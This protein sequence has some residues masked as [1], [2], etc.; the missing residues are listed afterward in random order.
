MDAKSQSGTN[1]GTPKCWDNITII[2]SPRQLF[3]NVY[4]CCLFLLLVF[5]YDRLHLV[6]KERQT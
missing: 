1:N 6:F 2:E 3:Q 5:V 4:T